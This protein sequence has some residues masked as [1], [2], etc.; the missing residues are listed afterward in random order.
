MVGHLTGKYFLRTEIICYIR[1][2]ERGPSLPHTAVFEA[3]ESFK[4]K[5]KRHH[6][7]TA[8]LQRDGQD[9]WKC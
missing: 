6:P 8:L 3:V 5:F 9:K 1:T 7:H 4:V 2:S